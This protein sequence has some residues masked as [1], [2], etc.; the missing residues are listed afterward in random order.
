MMARPLLDD[1][2]DVH[3]EA[4]DEQQQD[5][6]ELGD[7]VDVVAVGDQTEGE[8]PGDDAGE[9]VAGDGRQVQAGKD[10]GEHA[11]QE[12]AD[13]DV[14]N[15]GRHFAFGGVGRRTDRRPS[16]TPAQPATHAIP[17]A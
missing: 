10:D 3:L 14:M 15:E 1:L 12:Q 4:D 9:D 6:A 5:E 11:G 16:R 8:R 13:A 17:M 7:G 2:A